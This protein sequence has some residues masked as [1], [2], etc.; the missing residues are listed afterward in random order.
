MNIKFQGKRCRIPLSLS[1]STS[2]LLLEGVGLHLKYSSSLIFYVFLINEINF[3]D[4][5][6]SYAS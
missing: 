2:L 1:G 3:E 6:L 5:V 4:E